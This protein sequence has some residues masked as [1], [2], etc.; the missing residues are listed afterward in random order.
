MVAVGGVLVQVLL[1]DRQELRL[2][3]LRHADEHADDL[4][5]QL[6][7]EVLHEVEPLAPDQAVDD[8]LAQSTDLALEPAHRRGVNNRDTIRGATCATADPRR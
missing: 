8:L 7:R 2:I 6:E 3:L 5:R 1:E 4:H